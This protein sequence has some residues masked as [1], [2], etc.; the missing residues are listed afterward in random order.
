MPAPADLETSAGRSGIQSRSE[1]HRAGPLRYKRAVHRRYTTFQVC[2]ESLF[3]VL[4]SRTAP[5]MA[6]CE[7]GGGANPLLSRDERE[8]LR[9]T[10][11]LIDIDATELA[12]APDDLHKVA[13]DITSRPLPGQFDIIVSKHLAEHVTDPEAMHRH[14]WAMLRPG[15]I[16][17]HFFPTLYSAPFMLNRLI[18]ERLAERIL[19]YLQ[20]FRAKGGNQRKFPAYYRWCR[21]PTRHQIRRLVRTGLDV[22]EY[23]ASFGHAYYVRASVLQRLEDA[24]TRFLLRHPSALLT[25]YAVVVLRRP[26]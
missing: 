12:K 24:K 25:S 9:L 23:I 17:I 11:T 13:L 16:A 22:E 18:P 10:Y 4:R 7:I 1:P 15:G 21:G 20:P 3:E 26:G 8:R 6:I 19:L 2:F 14:I 5:G